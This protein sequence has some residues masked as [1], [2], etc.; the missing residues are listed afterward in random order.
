MHG[1]IDQNLA[2]VKAVA[3]KSEQFIVSV[4]SMNERL[5]VLTKA[6]T[7]FGILAATASLFFGPLLLTAFSHNVSN[8]WNSTPFLNSETFSAA[9]LPLVCL[10]TAV[11]V[12]YTLGML[13]F[14]GLVA[15]EW[16]RER[17]VR[18]FPTMKLHIL[19]EESRPQFSL[20][21][22]I[23]S[24]D[25]LS[26]LRDYLILHAP[27]FLFVV[28]GI[29]AIEAPV[30]VVVFYL[31]GLYACH[32]YMLA[33]GEEELW[34]ASAAL[35]TLNLVHTLY[36]CVVAWFFMQIYEAVYSSDRTSLIGL[37]A[38]IASFLY[39]DFLMYIRRIKLHETL[40]ALALLG[41]FFFFA[42]IGPGIV[43]AASLRGLGVGGGLP[44]S[45]LVKSY[46]AGAKDPTLAVVRGCVALNLGGQVVIEEFRSPPFSGA[47]CLIRHW[48]MA[49]NRDDLLKT[50]CRISV[51]AR[52]DIVRISSVDARFDGGGGGSPAAAPKCDEPQTSA[53]R[54]G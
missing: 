26:D 29:L 9:L 19:E 41:L 44:A 7:H 23:P 11:L 21:A 3:G 16:F 12:S 20:G 51:Y 42:V 37:Y 30:L 45:M 43:G 5:E 32:F 2:D 49:K 4:K 39:V 36:F 50:F 17:L 14:S 13:A 27:T 33:K 22:L 53:A 15:R 24:R 34:R 35:L 18:H 6:I 46:E 48:T 8:L 54:S 40:L 38:G 28:S 1:L 47:D 25:V 31:L 10:A 52:S